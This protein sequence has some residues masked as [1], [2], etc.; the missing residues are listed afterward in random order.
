MSPLAA[1]F[2]SSLILCAALALALGWVV[3]HRVSTPPRRN[4]LRELAGPPVHTLFGSH[5]PSL[6]DASRSPKTHAQYVEKYGR[7]VRIRGLGPWDE[8]LLPFDPL[9]VAHVLKNS[10][11]YEK[12]WQ[13]RRV[14]AGLVG[15]GMLAVEGHTHKRQRRVA[16]PAFSIQNLRELMPLVFRKGDELQ[17]RWSELV[18]E[19]PTSDEGV[20]I[21]VFRWI[22]RATF[23]VIGLA[24]FDYHFDAIHNETDELFCAYKDLFELFL[25]HNSSIRMLLA[26]YFPIVDVLF[27]DKRVK[28]MQRCR[29]VINRVAGNLIQVKKARIVEGEK[30]GTA[31]TDKDLLSLLLKSNMATDLPPD[32]RISD[33]DILHTVNTFM[34]AGSDTSSLA[35]TWTL[36]LLAKHP[37]IQTRLRTE[38]LN[39]MPPTPLS[40]L[41]PE[42][43]ESLYTVLSDHHLLNN[44]V[45][46]VLRLIPPLHSTMRVATRDDEIPTSSPVHLRDGSISEHRSI[47]VQK[48]DFV[49]IPVEAFHLD[50]GI[51]GD[52]AWEFD[53]DRWDHL[54]DAVETLPGA[55]S[56]L[57]TFS[58]GP[59][60]CI[61]MR[62]SVIEIKTFLYLLLT[63]FVFAEA[64]KKVYKVNVVLTRPYV[65]GQF[66]KGTQCPLLVKKIAS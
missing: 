8:R 64:K 29:S 53:P 41:T 62:F 63:N 58:A 28:L 47:S 57:L 51:W 49:Q 26:L 3:Y 23:D 9:S 4:P 43:F 14:I 37:E 50:K 42:E 38:L 21:D 22:S 20:E 35:V 33:E 25:A 5:M 59:R 2:G 13:S 11:V 15:R 32:Q 61:G 18:D 52:N 6:L 30:N 55:Y 54:P 40:R 7:S 31:C 46:E 16:T 36:F 45:R 24:G 1:T 39:I 34:F 66:K 65:A 10:T 60:S 44:V 56:N 27:P 17:E 19:Q 12:P 48:G